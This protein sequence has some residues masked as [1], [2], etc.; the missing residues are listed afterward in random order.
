MRQFNILQSKLRCL[1]LRR[2]RAQLV[3]SARSLPSLLIV[4]FSLIVIIAWTLGKSM[5]LVFD[6]FE[7]VVC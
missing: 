1:L 2:W 6:P 3:C 4:M 7:S 5:L